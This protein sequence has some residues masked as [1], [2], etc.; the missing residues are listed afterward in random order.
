MWR[1]LRFMSFPD[2]KP[3]AP[4]QERDIYFAGTRLHFN[5]HCWNNEVTVEAAKAARALLKTEYVEPRPAGEGE[6]FYRLTAAGRAAAAGP[7]P[8]DPVP[9]PPPLHAESRSL[10]LSLAYNPEEWKKPRHLGGANGSHHSE[11]LYRLVLHGLVEMRKNLNEPVTGAAAVAIPRI[12]RRG[13][14]S[15]M[16]RITAAGLEYLAKT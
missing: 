4:V 7:A 10:L 9:T 2:R 13:K 8:I 12:H 6:D 1:V 11:S 14:G 15:R 16:F 3:D 5:Y